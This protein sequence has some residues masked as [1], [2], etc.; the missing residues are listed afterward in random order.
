[1][2]Q[3]GRIVEHGKAGTWWASQAG[4]VENALVLIPP[5]TLSLSFVPAFA[6]L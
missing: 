6:G 4:V 1:V 5:H 3:I 2:S